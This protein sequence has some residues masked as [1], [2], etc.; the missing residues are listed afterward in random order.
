MQCKIY[1]PA[2]ITD[3]IQPSYNLRQTRLKIFTVPPPLPSLPINSKDG[4]MARFGSCAASSLG[5]GGGLLFLS[6]RSKIV[7]NII[8]RWVY[9]EKIRDGHQM[10]IDSKQKQDD[11]NRLL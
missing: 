3:R 8:L 7:L 4:K 5:W 10:S 9:E 11:K 1:T 2:T 6:I